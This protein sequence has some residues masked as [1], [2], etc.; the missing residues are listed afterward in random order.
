MLSGTLEPRVKMELLWLRVGEVFRTRSGFI[1]PLFNPEPSVDVLVANFP[2][3]VLA[4]S[5]V[6]FVDNLQITS[7][8]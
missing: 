1:V 2:P 6:T 8:Q 7:Y 3:W 5:D 4:A